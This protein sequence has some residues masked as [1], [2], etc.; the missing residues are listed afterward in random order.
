[1]DGVILVETR[2]TDCR[3]MS[4]REWRLTTDKM[5]VHLANW[6]IEESYETLAIPSTVSVAL[7]DASALMYRYAALTFGGTTVAWR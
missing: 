6:T 7:A 1:M 5:D 4:A 2:E 3:L